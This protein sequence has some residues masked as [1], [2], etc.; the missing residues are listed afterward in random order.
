MNET[1]KKAVITLVVIVLALGLLFGLRWFVEN[2][3]NRQTASQNQTTSPIVDASPAV[4][5]S[6]T[7]TAPAP[8]KSNAASDAYQKALD[9]YAFRIQFKDC[10]GIGEPPAV[11]GSLVLKKGT[12]LMLDNRDKVAHTIAFKGVS[13]RVGAENF[14]VVTASVLGIYNVTCDGGGAA[15]LNVE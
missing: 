4:P 6:A 5:Q 8:S 2:V 10:H 15:S 1:Q 11:G 9:T 12:K 13:V 14:A 3:S 7:P